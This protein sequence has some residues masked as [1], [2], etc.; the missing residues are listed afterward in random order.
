MDKHTLICISTQFHAFHATN[1]FKLHLS[2][3]RAVISHDQE[4]ICLILCL[5]C[6]MFLLEH[7][8]FYARFV[9]TKNTGASVQ[10]Q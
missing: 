7:I 10:P 2:T 9:S 5:L 4:I 6:E 8:K 1:S 3:R